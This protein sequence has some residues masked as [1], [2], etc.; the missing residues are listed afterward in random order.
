MFGHGDRLE[1]E[2]KVEKAPD[3]ALSTGIIISS[4]SFSSGVLESGCPEAR[5]IT[6]KL[7]CSKLMALIKY[8]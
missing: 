2:K 8:I 3:T 4:S 5:H 6:Q 7:T 1:E